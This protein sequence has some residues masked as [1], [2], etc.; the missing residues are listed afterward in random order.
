MTKQ[1]PNIYDITFW[2]ANTKKMINIMKGSS[3]Y[4]HTD[5]AILALM[6]DQIQALFQWD[7][8][9]CVNYYFYASYFYNKKSS[10]R[11]R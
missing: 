11:G 8:H 7:S 4:M 5:A 10:F 2:Y 1:A 3:D 6:H 9:Q